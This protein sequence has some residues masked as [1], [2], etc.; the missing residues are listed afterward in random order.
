MNDTNTATSKCLKTKV[1]FRRKFNSL[2]PI[3]SVKACFWEEKM[4]NSL[5]MELLSTMYVLRRLFPQE[6][7]SCMALWIL[8]LPLLVVKLNNSLVLTSST[9][10]DLTG[11]R[12]G[13]VKD[14]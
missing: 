10:L 6:Y 2:V 9:S 8:F 12:V 14:N 11:Y 13:Y 4:V 7:S 1:F 5:E 3:I